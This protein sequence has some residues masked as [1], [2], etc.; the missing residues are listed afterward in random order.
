MTTMNIET[1]TLSYGSHRSREQGLCAM[2]AVAW[3]AGEPHSDQPQC[4]CPVIAAF[5]RRMNDR[6]RDDE[7]RARYLRP[8]L[9]VLIGTRTDSREV[10]QRRAY[11]A[12][13]WAVRT[14]VPML[15][16]A[17]GR[18][19]WAARL[20]A[21]APVVDRE[22]ALV[23]RDVAREVHAAAAYAAAYAAAAYA[24][25]AAAAYAAAY[26]ADDAADA[27]ADAAYAADAYADDAADAYAAARKAAI[28]SVRDAINASA[29]E[30]IRRMCE[31]RPE[32]LE[33][34]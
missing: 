33:V 30:L 31:E 7:E 32:P 9:P 18:E 28:A 25:Y 5:V 16:R 21:C 10:M 15:F 1:I 11:L 27:Y 24:A 22:T 19:E 2:E 29:V 14:S 20:E 26:A 17:L 23:A 4:T 12:A 13:D 8:L 6:L 34:E 3:L